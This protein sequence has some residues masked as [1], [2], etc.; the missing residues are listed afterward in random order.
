MAESGAVMTKIAVAMHADKRVNEKLQ[1]V[2][3]APMS[4]AKG[5]LLQQSDRVKGHRHPHGKVETLSID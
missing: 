3:S 5:A 1:L 2:F 4:N